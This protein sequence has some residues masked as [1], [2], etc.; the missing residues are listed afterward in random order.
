MRTPEPSH[1]SDEERWTRQSIKEMA[2]Q[3]GEQTHEYLAHGGDQV[4]LQVRETRDGR[5]KGI[6]EKSVIK[7]TQRYIRNGILA[8]AMR[9]ASSEQL[10]QLRPITRERL[11]KTLESYLDQETGEA[12]KEE[13]KKELARAREYERTVKKYFKKDKVLRS[14]ALVRNVPVSEGAVSAVLQRY[15]GESID[16]QKDIEVPTLVRVQSRIPEVVDNT[17]DELGSLGFRYMERYQNILPDEVDRMNAMGFSAEE[18]DQEFIRPFFQEGTMH[19]LERAQEDAEL[20]SVMQDFV[21]RAIRLAN[22]GGEMMDIAGSGNVKFYQTED[23]GWD[24]LIIDADAHQDW[25]GMKE[26]LSDRMKE[27]P[28]QV[29]KAWKFDL[30][31]VTEEEK[32]EL[33][34]EGIL[35]LER[36]KYREA[37]KEQKARLEARL[38]ST[39]N[40]VNYARSMNMLAKMLDL[41]DRVD[42]AE[43]EGAERTLSGV[44]AEVHRYNDTEFRGTRLNIPRNA[45]ASNADITLLPFDATMGDPGNEKM[46]V[47]AAVDLK[48]ETMDGWI[49]DGDIDEDADTDEVEIQPVPSLSPPEED[50]GE[51]VIDY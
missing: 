47:E 24:Y 27:T 6:R 12:S 35:A 10:A 8:E 30:Q 22:E 1:M 48:D 16:P 25:A 5:E 34:E 9:A 49:I 46:T 3:S 41:P 42:I 13:L 29:E 19:L 23:G 43:L 50:T 44:L 39:L 45:G 51:T 38:R 11:E 26:R 2:D 40:G 33:D 14:V 4:V 37:R 32:E 17:P 28:E 36:V 20:R 7:L 15:G 31:P 21:H 18:V